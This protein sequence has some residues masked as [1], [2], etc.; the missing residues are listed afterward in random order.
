MELPRPG[1]SA[2]DYPTILA[3]TLAMAS[4]FYLQF[5]RDPSRRALIASAGGVIF[6]LAA[7]GVALTFVAT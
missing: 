1:R 5:G 2:D 7:I 4:S 3:L 6:G